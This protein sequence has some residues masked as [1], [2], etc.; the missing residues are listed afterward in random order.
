MKQRDEGERKRQ[1]RL[2]FGRAIS[3]TVEIFQMEPNR[4]G[5]DQSNP[6]LVWADNAADHPRYCPQNLSPG[7]RKGGAS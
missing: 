1:F 6:G 2:S 5:N 4:W 3:A 7:A